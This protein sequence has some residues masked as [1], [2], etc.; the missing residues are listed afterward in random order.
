MYEG[1]Y[2]KIINRFT[3]ETV[4]AGKVI[5]NKQLPFKCIT[6]DNRYFFNVSRKHLFY[7][8][9]VCDYCDEVKFDDTKYKVE[10]W[11]NAF[12]NSKAF[13]FREYDIKE[14]DD[15][16][17]DLVYAINN[18]PIRTSG[19]CCGHGKYYAWVDMCFT[20][21]SQIRKI[22]DI[23]NINDF[24]NKFT[25]ES[26]DGIV[27]EDSSVIT[28][29]FRTNRIGEKAYKDIKDLVKYINLLKDV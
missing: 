2:C 25:L 4:V 16:I 15:E 21:F 24:K 3:R 7:K 23:L 14:L 19:S 17:K 18:I 22:I 27:N 6:F 28:L 9:I 8:F 1:N 12:K 10:L 5:N 20:N 13:V 11:R 29:R 26:N